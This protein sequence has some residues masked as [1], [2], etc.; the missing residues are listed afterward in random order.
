[1]ADSYPMLGALLLVV[2]A[3]AVAAEEGHVH[4]KTVDESI[5]ESLGNCPLC[6]GHEPCLIN[7]RLKEKRAW[8]ECL[9]LC[10]HDNPMLKETL[11]SLVQDLGSTKGRSFGA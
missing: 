5:V 8:N 4:V 1:M 7:C 3:R 6:A 10:L 2:G 11:T 9:D